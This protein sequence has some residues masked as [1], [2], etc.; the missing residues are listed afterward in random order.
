[1]LVTAASIG[2]LSLD[3][4]TALKYALSSPPERD[5]NARASFIRPSISFT[6]RSEKA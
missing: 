1:M 6:R 4:L 5:K 3:A 2:F